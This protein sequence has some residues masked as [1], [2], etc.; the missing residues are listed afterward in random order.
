MPGRASFVKRMFL[1]QHP[2][3]AWFRLNGEMCIIPC[4]LYDY[5]NPPAPGS[6][7]TIR[8]VGFTKEMHGKPRYPYFMRV[9]RDV[10]WED[11][12]KEKRAEIGKPY[13][14]DSE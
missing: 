8:H 10:T 5:T 3:T 2:L 12:K 13:K 11:L 14:P 4:S 1:K 7:L 9:R 6:V